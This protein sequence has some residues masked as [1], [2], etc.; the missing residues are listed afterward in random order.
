MPSAQA[1]ISLAGTTVVHSDCTGIVRFEVAILRHLA[2]LDLAAV[3]QTVDLRAA[4]LEL[5]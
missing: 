4:I 2:R 3:W 1:L 5:V